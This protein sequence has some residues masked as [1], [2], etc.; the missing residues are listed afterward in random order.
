MTYQTRSRRAMLRAGAAVSAGA[1]AWLAACGGSKDSGNTQS[2][3]SRALATADTR[4]TQSAGASTPAAQR[5]GT[6]RVALSA[7]PTG[8]DP[9]TSRG[10]GDHHWLYSIFDNLVNNDPKF[11][12]APGIAETWEVIDDLTVSFKLQDG[13]T[14]HD[15]TPFS[16]EDVKYTIARHQD[17]ATK[18]YAAGQ[19][20][21]IDRVEVVDK[22]RVVFKLKDVTASLFSILGDRPGMI[23]SQAAVQ[24][25]GDQFTNKPIG[26]GPMKLDSWTVDASVK[27]SR[28]DK[29]RKQGLPY[30]DAMDIQV[31]PNSSVQFAN[32]RSGNTDLIVVG[33]KDAEAAKKDTS[34]QYVQWPSTG[35]TQVNLNLSQP[36]LTD[37]RVR[38]AMSYA[39]NRKAILEGIYFGE[40]E[41]ANGP[42]TRASWAFNESLQP[43]PEDLKKAKD[44][45]T[46]A[47][48]PNGLSWDMVITPGEIDTPLAEMLK[49]QWARV[50]ININL[51][52]RNAEQAGAEYRDQKYPMFLVGFSGRADPDP[53]IYENFHSKGGFNRAT[54]NKS[55]VPDDEQREL[56]AKILKAR[57]VYDQKKRKELY[58]DIQRQIVEN[59]HGI[60]FTHQTNR[61]GLSKRV[62]GFNPY[63][64]GK[65]RLAEL[66][67][68]Q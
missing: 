9:A 33:Q 8:L 26:S 43:I 12:A 68:Q 23:F 34:I 49:S 47:G 41:I 60:L 50:G 30:L 67:I 5:G 40:G 20:T 32:L 61:V 4:V 28:F 36:P 29:F 37:I 14:Y 59:A 52:P 3:A 18:S 53:T 46:A 66:W 57:Q 31:V 25:G 27:L 45:L 62:R 16:A 63:G 21:S 44:L 42:I 65:L 11:Q 64:D 55:Y 54:F 7:D 17:P 6:L 56:D 13:F 51:V 35:Y 22:T 10:G 19:V 2:G 24:K 58:D 39:L 38:Q 48:H 1:A 15:G